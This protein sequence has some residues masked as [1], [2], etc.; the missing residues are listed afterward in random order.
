MT[1]EGRGGEGPTEAGLQLLSTDRT[2]QPNEHLVI[3]QESL[4]QRLGEGGIET[5]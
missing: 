3:S 1:G 4:D 2:L 5:F